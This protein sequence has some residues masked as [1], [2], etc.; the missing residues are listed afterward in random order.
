MVRFCKDPN[1]ETVFSA[2]NKTATLDNQAICQHQ[3]QDSLSIDALKQRV[4]H[5]ENEVAKQSSVSQL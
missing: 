3:G 1:G 2:H 5:L 4:K